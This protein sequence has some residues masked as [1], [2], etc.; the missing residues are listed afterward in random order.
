M[1]FLNPFLSLPF[2]LL[3]LIIA[4]GLDRWVTTRRSEFFDKRNV[5]ATT[6]RMVRRLEQ[7]GY[8]VNLEV[9]TTIAV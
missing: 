2:M 9:S 8:K 1:R 6:R 7:L 5:Q 4:F 3:S